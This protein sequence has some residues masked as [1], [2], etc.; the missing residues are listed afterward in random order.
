MMFTSLMIVVM[1]A[2]LE[3]AN[4]SYSRSQLISCDVR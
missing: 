4:G 1:F 3:L 2:S